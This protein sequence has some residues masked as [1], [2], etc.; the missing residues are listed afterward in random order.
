MGRMITM[1]NAPSPFHHHLVEQPRLTDLALTPD[2]TRLIASVQTLDDEGTRYVSE[3]WEVDPAGEREARL[4]AGSVPGDSAPAFTADGSLLFLS[5]RDPHEPPGAALW[6]LSE[7]GEAERIVHHPGGVT[8]FTAAP[9]A[10]TLAWTAALLPGAADADTHAALLHERHRARVTAVLYEATPTRAGGVDLGPAEPHTFVRRGEAPPVD[11]GGQGLAGAGDMALSPD[12]SVVAYTRAPTSAAPDTNVVVIAD[13]AT[14]MERRT[15]SLPGHQYHRPV[16]TADGTRLICQRQREETYDMEWR[17][18]LVALDPVSGEETDLLPDFDNWPW[19]GRAIPS[20]VAGDAT[21]W[22]TGDER[23]H[24]PVFRRDPDGT[25]T[26]LTASGAYSS[27][28][29]TP[30]GS[31]LYALRGALDSSPQVT[32]LDATEPD[33]QPTVL[34]APGDLGPLPG[35]LTEVHT[36]ADDGFALRAWLILPEGAGPDHPSPLLVEAH[37]GPQSS[38]SGW[39]GQWNPWPFVA[40]GYA[41]L[42]PD[43][44]LSTGY[45]QQ[46]QARGRGQYGGR[47][48]RDVIALTDAAL[49]RADLDAGRTALAGWS[50]GG[51]LAGRAATLTDR[52]RAVVTHAGMWNMEVF[53][54]D[55]DMHTYFRKIYGDPR[56]RRERYEADSPHLDVENLTTPMLI[57]HGGKDYRVPVGQ[58]LALHHDLQ[59]QGVPAKFLYFPDESHGIGAPN[60]L[61]LVYETALNFLDHHVLGEEW[62]RPG[63]V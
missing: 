7:N 1:V 31:L 29:V 23:G 63:L 15:F 25:V 24:C 57:V 49:A 39:P 5:E 61:R 6:A 62:K 34:K 36:T 33:Q 46:M 12:G 51:Y 4:V 10:P 56:T 54:S 59:R 45:G 2:G 30:D 43:P 13:A 11:A 41:V 14:G 32:R 40:R 22:F 21:L 53:Q 20:P 18:T 44:A 27:L 26:R 38:W 17:V 48:Y 37:G 16:F 47:P 50:F 28:C 60:H 9:G 19:P 58:S 42:L 55:T 35:S 52:F 3:L 8:A